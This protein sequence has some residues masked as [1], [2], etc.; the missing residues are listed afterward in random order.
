MYRWSYRIFRCSGRVSSSCSTRW[1]VWTNVLL[2]RKR[3]KRKEEKG[4]NDRYMWDRLAWRVPL[5]EQE[6]LTIPE[7]LSSPPV[8]SGVRVTRS[9]VLC[10]CFVNRCL[11]YCLFSFCHCVV[12]SS[13]FWPLCRLFFCLLT[14]VS[15]VLLW[16]T[17][18]DYPFGIFKLFLESIVMPRTTNL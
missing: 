8:F 3:K 17:D 4:G 13:V 15:S 5:V 7:H 14:I 10:V 11:S 1:H 18:S 12:C 6:L 2:T 16:Y 9:L